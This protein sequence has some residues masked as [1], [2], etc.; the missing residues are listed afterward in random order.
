MTFDEIRNEDEMEPDG[1]M[2]N[3]PAGGDTGE[4]TEPEDPMHGG[5]ADADTE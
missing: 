1:D 5:D 2:K 3:D 4:D